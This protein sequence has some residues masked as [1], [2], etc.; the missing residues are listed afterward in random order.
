VTKS[1][2]PNYYNVIKEPMDLQKITNRVEE[3]Q[4]QRLMDFIGDVVK[5]FENCRYFNESTTDIFRHADNLEKFFVQKI[6]AL[7]QSF[8]TRA[9]QGVT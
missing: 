4:Y 5:I 8:N 1:Q 7:R 3:R 6:W 9:R 2:A